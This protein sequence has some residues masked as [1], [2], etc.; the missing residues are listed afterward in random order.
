MWLE[1]E[2][3]SQMTNPN[4]RTFLMASGGAAA[5]AGGA[6]VAR[7]ERLALAGGPRSVTFPAEKLDAL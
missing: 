5:L 6:S 4:R 1:E 2:E 3:D 7:A